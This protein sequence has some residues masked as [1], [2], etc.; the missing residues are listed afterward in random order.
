MSLI[1]ICRDARLVEHFLQYA[2]FDSNGYTLI[3][4][5]DKERSMILQNN[6][7]HNVY[8][9]NGQPNLERSIGGIIVSIATRE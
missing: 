7:P 8:V 1:W 4:L 3:Y 6:L 2:N 9:I 5:T